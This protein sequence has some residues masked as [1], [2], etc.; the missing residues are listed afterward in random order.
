MNLSFMYFE[1]HNV[2]F[3]RIDLKFCTDTP[4]TLYYRMK[5]KFFDFLTIPPPLKGREKGKVSLID[6]RMEFHLPELQ[7]LK[8]ELRAR[9]KVA[10]NKNKEEKA[11]EILETLAILVK[12]EKAFENIHQAHRARLH[13][14]EYLN[15]GTKPVVEPPVITPKLFAGETRIL[16]LFV[17]NIIDKTIDKAKIKKKL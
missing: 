9:E 13:K 3:H 1:A 16:K 10:R 4:E 8:Q 17:L 5:K 15:P 12:F 14:K 11:D 2:N 6:F 7:E